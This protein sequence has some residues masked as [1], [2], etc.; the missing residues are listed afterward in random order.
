MWITTIIV[1]LCLPNI[2]YAFEMVLSIILTT[3]TPNREVIQPLDETD[4]INNESA[5]NIQD[6]NVVNA[7]NDIVDEMV[8]IID[9]VDDVTNIE[10]QEH[11]EIVT[12][13]NPDVV[14]QE[15]DDTDEIIQ[16]EQKNDVIIPISEYTNTQSV[17]TTTPI[18]ENNPP[19]NTKKKRKR[20]KSIEDIEKAWNTIVS[21]FR[22]K[23][24]K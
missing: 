19:E 14:T 12:E 2:I 20:N 17:D 6:D 18:H 8:A 11:N 1:A 9:N 4:T 7:V 15:T 24:K 5:H 13:E 16:V 10:P 21:S 23:K 22:P 3:R